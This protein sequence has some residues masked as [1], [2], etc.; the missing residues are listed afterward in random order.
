[1]GT[2]ARR[3]IAAAGMAIGA[4]AVVG[5]A[6]AAVPSQQIASSGPLTAITIGE[7]LSCQV[8]HTGDSGF[9]LF[10]ATVAPG[11]CGTFVFTSGELF[12]PS[13]SA[14][15]S[16]ATQAL[17]VSTA[18]TAV[19]QSQA[20][21]AGTA[22][23]PFKVVTVV[24][25]G[26]GMRIT[27][28]DSYVVGQESYR[29]DTTI[30]NLSDGSRD[31][32]LYRAGDCYLQGSDKGYGFVTPA[33]GAV[34]CAV[35]PQNSPR[36]R[37][38]QW[39][40]ITSGNQF[41]EDRYSSVWAAIGRHVPF[42]N[43]ARPVALIDNGA[44]ISWAFT[45]AK[46]QSTTFSHYTTFSPSGVTGPPPPTGAFGPGGLLEVPPNGPC[47]AK[48]D[49]T[50]AVRDE[51]RAV[52]RRVSLR[53]AGTLHVLRGAPWTTTFDLSAVMR[54]RFALKVNAVMSSGQTITGTRRYTLCA[55]AAP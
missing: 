46:D 50:V 37:I 53:V 11:D 12:A 44:G 24:D 49:F 55:T 29:T 27:Q 5:P 33:A 10:P 2:R 28:V 42:P 45:L 43:T 34:A 36:G 19:S 21:G 8:A 31:G 7:D 51:Y 47:Y 30:E 22:A 26:S 6:T 39:F 18:F 41:I 16:T 40:P 13:F 17:G 3:R 35:N 23:S 54:R 48:T 52:T 25:A 4:F 9:E 20:S 38:E 14:H 15:D 1:M 32:V